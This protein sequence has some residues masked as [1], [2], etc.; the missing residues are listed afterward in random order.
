MPWIVLYN[1][2]LYSIHSITVSFIPLLSSIVWKF[3]VQ[4]STKCWYRSLFDRE[5]VRYYTDIK[6]I[7]C[8]SGMKVFSTFQRLRQEAGILL[9]Y[10]RMT[11]IIHTHTTTQ[12]IQNTHQLVSQQQLG[13]QQCSNHT[14]YTVTLAATSYK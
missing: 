3:Y 2:P 13:T 14:S 10:P 4:F 12:L 11:P 9:V 7:C 5:R 6:F 1:N 8:L